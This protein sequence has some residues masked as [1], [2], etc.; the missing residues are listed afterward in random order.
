MTD[1]ISLNSFLYYTMIYFL[2]TQPQEA[3]YLLVCSFRCG[4]ILFRKFPFSGSEEEV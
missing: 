2:K 4:N 3:L 1:L